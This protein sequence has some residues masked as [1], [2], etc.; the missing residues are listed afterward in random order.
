MTER[1]WRGAF[2]GFLAAAHL[3]G[4]TAALAEE[5]SLENW[6]TVTME[7][8][9]G[10]IHKDCEAIVWVEGEGWLDREKIHDLGEGRIG[11]WLRD[12]RAAMIYLPR[13]RGR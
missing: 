10:G 6:W 2:A 8:R 13:G 3:F 5:A 12:G 11:L 4:A 7:S 1:T 9:H